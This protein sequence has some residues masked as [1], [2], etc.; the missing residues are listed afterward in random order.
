MEPFASEKAVPK[1][2]AAAPEATMQHP[3]RLQDVGHLL[4][5]ELRLAYDRPYSYPFQESGDPSESRGQGHILAV[6][7]FDPAFAAVRDDSEH[8]LALDAGFRNLLLF[9]HL[10]PVR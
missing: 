3:E 4:R 2:A 6:Q 1:R 7:E 10:F 5:L 9:A 8:N